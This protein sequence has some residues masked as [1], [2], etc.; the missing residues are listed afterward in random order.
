MVPDPFI[1]AIGNFLRIARKFPNLEFID[2]GGGF[3][4]PYHKLNDEAPFD[5]DKL[6]KE[7]EPI[8]DD[9]VS[10]YGYAP[11]FKSE[12][13]RYCVAESSLILGPELISE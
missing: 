2:F 5:I 4:T 9:F 8:L 13:G 1:Q 6:S 12:P 10:D 7:M 3:G 11:L